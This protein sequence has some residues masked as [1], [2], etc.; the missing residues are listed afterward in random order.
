MMTETLVSCGEI[1][2]VKLTRE[3][4][5]YIILRKKTE[6]NGNFSKALPLLRLDLQYAAYIFFG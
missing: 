3:S 2:I 5:T 4:K 6:V 1:E